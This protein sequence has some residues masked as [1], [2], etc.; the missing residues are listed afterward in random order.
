L[1]PTTTM[2][3]VRMANGTR[4]MAANNGTKASTITTPMI[5]PVYIEAISPHTNSGFSLNSIGPGCSPQ[6][7][8]PPSITAAVGEPGMPSVIIGSMAATPAAWAAVS[9]ATTPS[10][11]PLP[12]WSPRGG[13]RGAAGL[14]ANQEA[15]EGAAQEGPPVAGQHLPGVQ[16]HPQIHP[17]LRAPE[18]QALLD[19]Q[20]DLADP[21]QT[22]DGDGEVEAL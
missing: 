5:L 12:D 20:Q 21:E 18:A 10:S 15:D 8:R 13:G 3:G 1:A 11:S 22:D 9:G 2:S 6:M 16:H 7:M 19:R 14:K 4:R 17:G